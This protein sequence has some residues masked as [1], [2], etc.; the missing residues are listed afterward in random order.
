MSRYHQA[1]AAD[2]YS[3]TPAVSGAWVLSGDEGHWFNAVPGEVVRIR[4]HDSDVGG[5]FTVLESVAQ[6]MAGTP[7]H[8]HREDEVFHVQEGVLTFVIDGNRFDACPGSIVVIPAGAVHAWRNF[9]DKPS[10]SIVTFTP[11]GIEE[12]FAKLSELALSNLPELAAHYGP[13]SPGRGLN[14]KS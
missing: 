4:I 5:R 9:G 12:L 6:P 11:G 8:A 13:P 14:S 1:A 7:S 2:D 10:R 3:T